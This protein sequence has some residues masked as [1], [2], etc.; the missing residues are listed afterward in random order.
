MKVSEAAYS[1]LDGEVKAIDVPLTS[2]R[3]CVWMCGCG[4]YCAS[5]LPHF[6]FLSR[7]ETQQ[8]EA[9]LQENMKNVQ[10]LEAELVA[11]D[12]Q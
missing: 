1:G 5:S 3:E 6:D 10:Q 4:C 9:K 7:Y 11:L 12:A 2:I 8:K